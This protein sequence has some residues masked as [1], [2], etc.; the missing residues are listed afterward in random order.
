[1]IISLPGDPIWLREG[2]L[3]AYDL[4]QHGIPVGTILHKPCRGIFLERKMINSKSYIKAYV[5]NVGERYIEED[6]VIE[7]NKNGD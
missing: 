6:E 7:L 1:M 4:P 5:D 3:I 2:V